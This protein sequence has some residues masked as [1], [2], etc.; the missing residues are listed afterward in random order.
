LGNRS[1]AQFEIKDIKGKLSEVPD[2][3]Y[4]KDY[5]KELSKMNFK[6][7][8]IEEKIENNL[9]TINK[10]QV[11][12]ENY[13]QDLYKIE[14]KITQHED[15]DKKLSIIK[16]VNKSI[17]E[18]TDKLARDKINEL[19]CLITKIFNAVSNKDDL[20][21]EISIDPD[22]FEAILHNRNGD[23]ISKD[24]LST[25]ER[26][27][28]TLSVLWGLTQITDKKFPLIFDSPFSNLDSSHVTK[29]IN[30]FFPNAANQVILLSHDR[31]IDKPVYEQLKPYLNKTYRLNYNLV[32]KLE[33]GYFYN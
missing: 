17:E 13:E 8:Q 3:E 14:E 21:K 26:E 15:A 29:L 12:K 1:T 28:Y 11:E 25:G 20:I 19:S 31:E 27:V 9:V 32:D 33:E 6:L 2:D 10:L 22:N 16:N 5:V 23:L 18:Y 4:I 30:N 7:E 24:E